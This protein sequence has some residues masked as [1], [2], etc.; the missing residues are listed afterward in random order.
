MLYYNITLVKTKKS[1]KEVKELGYRHREYGYYIE[2]VLSKAEEICE[3]N[4]VR[5]TEH[6]RR[7]LALIW[8]NRQPIKAYELLERLSAETG[9]IQPPTVYRALD[10]LLNQGL[11]HKLD[12][13]NA[14]LGCGDP[15]SGSDCFFLIC[16]DC[17]VTDE[18]SSPSLRSS[19]MDTA[20][21]HEFSIDDVTL[22]V[23][24]QCQHCRES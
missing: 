23:S 16:R 11:I 14:F 5:L 15:D 22:E 10:F 1:K 24:G 19:I 8:E 12:S 17:G 6:R 2:V 18:Y 21:G 3:K 20:K 13:L 9:K 4:G 7:V